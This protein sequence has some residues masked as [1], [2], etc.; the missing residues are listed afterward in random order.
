MSSRNPSILFWVPYPK[1][2]AP[3]QRYRVEL[4]LRYLEAEGIRYKI[5]PFMDEST[6]K[7][8]YQGGS[9]SRKL[10]GV[11]KG[12]FRRFSSLFTEVHRYDYVF[13]H[14]EAAPLGP[15]ILEWILARVLRRKYIYDFDD[16]IWIPNTS[17]ENRVI[18]G[19][20]AFWKVKYLCRWAY[21]IA[22][23]NEFLREYAA[24]FN[25]QAIY[26][27]TCVDTVYQHHLVKVHQEHQV[28]V[29]WTG[30]HSTLF[31]LDE[32]LPVL[33]R[34]QERVAFAFVVIADKDPRLPLR[35]YRF[36]RWN[37]ATEV[38]DLI[39]IDIGVMPLKADAWS[40]G[41]CGFKLIQYLSLGIPAVA[42]PVGVNEEIVLHGQTG[43]IAGN[44][45]EWEG[46][47]ARLISDFS[48]RKQMGD[49][50]RRHIVDNYSVDAHLKTFLELFQK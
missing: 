15:P 1:Q 17:E 2:Q 22:A 4:F 41:K 16:A 21:K 13:I 29:G 8:L 19:F 43:F 6:W 46:S 7:V 44:H 31:Y 25:D 50:G 39:N 45:D 24:R 20:K 48:L 9:L 33:Q 49:R 23:G 11:M 10:G 35:N 26:M 5:V 36:V 3:S 27:P 18:A 32:I 12:Y 37:E 47:L 28:V 40:E 34:L 42:S 14:R 38:Q 30:R